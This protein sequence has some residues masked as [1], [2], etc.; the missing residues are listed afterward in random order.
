[1]ALLTRE[2]VQGQE[3][4]AD[5]QGILVAIPEGRAGIAATLDFMVELT[6][7]FRHDITVRTM[8]ERIVARVPGK[9]YYGEAEAIQN[10]VRDNIRYTQDVY[11]VETVKPPLATAFSHSGDC[12]DM[13][14][15][16]GTLL[17]SIGHPVRYVAVGTETPGVFEH[18]YVETKIGPR[19]IGVET[20]EDVSL[21]WTPQPQLSRM[22]RNI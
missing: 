18:V 17:Q 9:N 7:Q 3:S 22:V 13:A 14:L 12:D 8:A 6:K 11:D 16:A 5:P 1:M 4:Q 19:W 2:Q 21:G 15:L 20:T 10:W